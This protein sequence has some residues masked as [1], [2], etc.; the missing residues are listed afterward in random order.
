MDRDKQGIARSTQP[1]EIGRAEFSPA[2]TPAGQ[3]EVVEL[4]LDFVFVPEPCNTP[5]NSGSAHVAAV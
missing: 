1:G 5:I 2:T 4:E 3:S